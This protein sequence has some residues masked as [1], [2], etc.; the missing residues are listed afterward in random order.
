MLRGV[1]SLT[2]AFRRRVLAGIHADLARERSAPEQLRAELTPVVRT[3]VAARA[4][5][6][7]DPVLRAAWAALDPTL[8]D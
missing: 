1:D 8:G 4:V 7:T 3:L 6:E 2:A 5:A